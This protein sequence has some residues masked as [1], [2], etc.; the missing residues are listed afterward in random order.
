MVLLKG[1]FHLDEYSEETATHQVYLKP[2]NCISDRD[3]I[4]FRDNSLYSDVLGDHFFNLHLLITHFCS[5]KNIF[6]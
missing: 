6:L 2:A 5:P 1:L 4:S 3:G